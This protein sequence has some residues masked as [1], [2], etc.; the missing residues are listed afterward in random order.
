MRNDD[1]I[2]G[3]TLGLG[4]LSVLGHVHQAS[5]AKSLTA[6]LSESE[7]CGRE[8]VARADSE[9]ARANRSDYEIRQLRGELR[10][11]QDRVLVVEQERNDAIAARIAV[12]QGRA[13]AEQ[14]ARYAGR[15]EA[16]RAARIGR[17]FFDMA[18]CMMRV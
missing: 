9:H 4:L 15:E 3:W 1:G 13:E 12:E 8:A 2:D 11:C 16:E 5:E 6:K 17:L 10:G 14:A 18:L 7:R